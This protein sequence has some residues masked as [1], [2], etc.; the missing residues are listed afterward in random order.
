MARLLIGIDHGT[1][2]VL[3]LIEDEDKEEVRLGFDPRTALQVAAGVL[4]VAIETA[5]VAGMEKEECKALV[6]AAMAEHL[7]SN[8]EG[9]RH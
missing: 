6:S 1:N 4:S 5:K 8:F 3:F 7:L 2:E 9:A